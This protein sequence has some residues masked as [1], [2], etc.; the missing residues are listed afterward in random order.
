MLRGAAKRL[1]I[2]HYGLSTPSLEEIFL[3]TT[4]KPSSSGHSIV[5]DPP[6]GT[7]KL[8][9]GLSNGAELDDTRHDRSS[10]SHAPSSGTHAHSSGT[11]AH[12]S[13]THVHSSSTH[14]RSS[15][16]RVDSYLGGSSNSPTY[17]DDGNSKG[18][19]CEG[20]AD[21]P[22]NDQ[23]SI[24]NAEISVASSHGDAADAKTSLPVVNGTSSDDGSGTNGTNRFPGANEAP[25]P[26]RR[27]AHAASCTDDVDAESALRP[28]KDRDAVVGGGWRHELRCFREMVRKRAVVASRDVRG[29]FFTLLLPVLAVAA[30]LVGGVL[31]IGFILV[32]RARHV[33]S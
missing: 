1:G 33:C 26:P 18:S 25:L 14:G 21:I 17:T 3:R 24:R 10:N 4:T 27:R 11:H 7:S 5:T 16:T 22:L 12:S 23:P 30:V 13:S 9:T 31:Y 6:A 28:F 20:M 29:A 15:S 2:G 19:G 32:C 8:A